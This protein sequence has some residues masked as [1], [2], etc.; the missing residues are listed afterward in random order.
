MCRGFESSLRYRS[1]QCFKSW[2]PIGVN[3]PA[4]DKLDNDLRFP[5]PLRYILSCIVQFYLVQNFRCL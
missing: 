5:K 3:I 4:G 1:N 2:P